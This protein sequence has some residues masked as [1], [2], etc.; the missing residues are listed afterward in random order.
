MVGGGVVPIGA[1][2][3]SGV[4]ILIIVPGVVAGIVALFLGMK[5]IGSI[6]SNGSPDPGVSSTI[7]PIPVIATVIIILALSGILDPVPIRFTGPKQTC[8]VS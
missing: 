8:P 6:M 4:T 7:V 1:T 3:M 5:L 2:V